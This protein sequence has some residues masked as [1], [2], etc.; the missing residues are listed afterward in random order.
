VLPL[1]P[2]ASFIAPT[3]SSAFDSAKWSSMTLLYPSAPQGLCSH[4]AT[5]W[6]TSSPPPSSVFMNCRSAAA[7]RW[8]RVGLYPIVHVVGEHLG[9][10]EPLQRASHV[11]VPG[12]VVHGVEQWGR[13]GCPAAAPERDVAGR[14]HACEGEPQLHPRFLELALR[15]LRAL[16][17]AFQ[18]QQAEAQANSNGGDPFL[19]PIWP[20]ASP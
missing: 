17:V 18:L 5:S 1:T 15:L 16:L 13:G 19:R 6:V 7:P 3:S 20:N 2:K 8:P 4:G 11:E 10:V 14:A 9:L 12:Q